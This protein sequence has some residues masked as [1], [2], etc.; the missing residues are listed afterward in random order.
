MDGLNQAE[1]VKV[2]SQY[3]KGLDGCYQR[4]LKREPLRDGRLMLKFR[5]RP[6]GRTSNVSIGRKYDGT[7]LKSCL[8]ALVRRWRFPQFRGE[9]I[10]IEYPLIFATRF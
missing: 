9:P 3:K 8:D 1:V 6:S 7:V 5:I 4:Q 2:I 10:D